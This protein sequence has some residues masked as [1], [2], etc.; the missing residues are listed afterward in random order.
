[1]PYHGN[2]TGALNITVRHCLWLHN[3]WCPPTEK[4]HCVKNVVGRVAVTSLH[5]H[6]LRGFI[7]KEETQ[8]L[9]SRGISQVLKLIHRLYGALSSAS[10]P[11]ISLKENMKEW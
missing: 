6:P 5:T 1:M 4:H 2:H 11:L 10:L 7:N 9:K 3:S 8:L